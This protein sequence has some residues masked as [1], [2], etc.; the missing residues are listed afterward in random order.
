VAK[1]LAERDPDVIIAGAGM[2]GATLALALSSGGLSVT[3]I[4]PQTFERQLAPR[5]DGRA[6]AISYAAFRQW[7]TLG[8]APLLESHAQP[9]EQI[10]VTD[11]RSPGA[12]SSAPYPAWL[13]FDPRES[14]ETSGGEPL[15]YMLE[16]RHIRAGLAQALSASP[17]TIL[18]PGE[19]AEV[20]SGPTG[21]RVHLLDG[22][23]LNAP[24]L[25]GADGKRSRVRAR[26]GVGVQGWTYNQVAIVATVALAQDHGGVA[27]EH[28]LPTGPFAILP[29]TAGRASLVW[30][31]RA[32]YGA[33]LMSAPDVLFAAH[34][35]R[36]F[37][38]FVG[39]V[40]V[41]GPRF[42][43]PLSIQIADQ[44]TAPRVALMG[45]AAHVVHPIAGQGLNM[46]L[47][48]A[49]ALAQVVT[50][51]ARL[52]EDFG[53]PNVLERYARWRSLDNIGVAAAT[54][55]FTRLFS[56]DHSLV[57]LARDVGLSVVNGI[58]PARRWLMA[59][60]G[61]AVG[62]LPKLLL[63]EPI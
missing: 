2:A 7:R 30:T 63:G 17:V 4:D 57:R 60:A 55:V 9:I 28:F 10:L 25:V 1:R 59:E 34:L 43:Y 29:L 22:R 35:T 3:L 56:T 8:V 31:E 37:G 41:I 62:D 12:S 20:H 39:R 42:S 23:V 47:K 32:R 54:D 19:V 6:S 58:E 11:G 61:G 16:N 40:D 36:R 38:E 52:G 46:G 13:R 15:G 53:S 49:A 27:Y 33:A 48:D 26:S 44:L 45:E 5:F 50:E 21:V 14:A 24:L 18:S 51:A